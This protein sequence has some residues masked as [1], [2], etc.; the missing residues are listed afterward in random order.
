MCVSCHHEQNPP[1]LK[2]RID[3]ASSADARQ[4]I[5]GFYNVE[6]TDKKWRWTGPV[7]TIAL[8]PPD[9]DAKPGVLKAHLYIPSTEIDQL[10]PITLTA[11]IS[12]DK[13][14]G[15]ATYSTGGSHEFIAQVPVDD[16]RS[17]LVP[18]TFSLDKYVSRSPA[19]N[20][21]LGIVVTDISIGNQ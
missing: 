2:S 17:N 4:L 11:A 8:R 16:L 6:G 7:F 15:E 21:D 13:E 18:V 9:S 10:G 19:D 3:V 1:E 20:R 5:S 12:D 14:I